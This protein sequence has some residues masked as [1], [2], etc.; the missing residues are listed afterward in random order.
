MYLSDIFN[1][2]NISYMGIIV[3]VIFNFE[4]ICMT[5][6]IVGEPLPAV[7][8]NLNPNEGMLTE[9]G[10]MTWMTPNVQMKTTTN[11]IGKAFG[12]MFSGES[13]FQN[14]YTARGGPGQITFASSFPGS[15][16]AFNIT[17]GKD[18]IV[19]KSGFLASETTVNLSTYIQ[20]KFGSGFFGGE[21]FVMQRLSGEG[22]AF[23][24]IDGY[25]CEYN[26]Q[27]GQSMIVDTGYLAVMDD[28]CSMSIQK[29]PGVKNMIFGG[30]GVFNTVVT[31]PGRVVLQTMPIHTVAGALRPFF[32][33]SK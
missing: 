22:L 23:V 33:A 18:L 30:E 15:I 32:S 24:E 29:V 12:R 6:E 7:I 8:C 11:G 17:K 5:Y 27:A 9:R 31:G 25:A 20:K 26:L 21:G 1:L 4:V 2:T 19:Q 14:E 16:K 13:I 10:S 3:F 28:S